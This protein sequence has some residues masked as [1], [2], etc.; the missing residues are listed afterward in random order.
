MYGRYPSSFVLKFDAQQFL[1]DCGE[2]SQMKM[3]EFHVKRSKIDH[4]FISHLH[5]D[6]IFGLPGFLNSYNL[7]G[8][9]KSLALYGPTGI[10]DF[11]EAVKNAS[12]AYFNYELVIHELDGDQR[13]DLGILGG[14]Q[15]T[16]FPLQHRILTYGYRFDEV[17]AGL[18]IRPE[19]IE[20]FN[21]TIEEMKLIK[22]G[23]SITR[24]QKAIPIE[25]L[26]FPPTAPRSF[27]YCSDTMYD[28]RIIPYIDQVN[29]LYHEATY[30]H[31][32]V[33][34]AHDRMH[35][36]TL[37]AATIARSANV[38]HLLIGHYSSRY[39]VLDP[40]LDEAKTVFANTSLAE[41]GCIFQII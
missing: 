23:Q 12:T 16:A 14:L 6:H 26:T 13:L 35:S 11:I 17:S 19:A 4:V 8:R 33:D 22:T 2:G 37:E 29:L 36:T 5:G 38:R 20:A 9:Q 27:A 39:K 7:N 28:K 15:V 41:E 1:I 32:L 31:E 40:L 21:L 10:A 24:D 18:N 34:K 25:S 30:L 3:S